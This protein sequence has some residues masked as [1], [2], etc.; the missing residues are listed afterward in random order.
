MYNKKSTPK[1]QNLPATEIRL[2]ELQEEY[3][4]GNCSKAVSDEYFLLLRT[5][6]RSLTLK[7]IKRKGFSL[8]GEKVE[9]IATD[10]TILLLRQYRKPGWKIAASFAGAL[11]W[12]VIEALYG[13]ADEDM[14]SSLNKTFSDDSNSKEIL[15]IMEE[16]N[17]PW[18]HK[19][20]SSIEDDAMSVL[21]VAMDEIKNLIDQAFDILPYKTFMR[22]L[23][24]LLHQFRKP[25]TR[26]ICSTFEEIYLTNKELQAFE[27][28]LLEIR[29]RIKLLGT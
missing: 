25:K 19:K 8:P 3:M 28:L 27:I 9:E 26:N 29:N 2:G 6:A 13:P 22:F 1:S 20:A 4:S 10:A 7:E 23:P 5:Y 16:A 12:K 21:N 11:R 17:T 24:W 18:S 15:D 14:V